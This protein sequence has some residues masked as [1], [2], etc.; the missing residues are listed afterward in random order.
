[1]DVDQLRAAAE[2][3]RAMIESS[4]LRDGASP[5]P[6]ITVSIGGAMARSGEDALN[7]MKRVDEALYTAKRTGRNRVCL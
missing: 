5:V 6:G 1:M 4:T 7:L 3:L 2:K